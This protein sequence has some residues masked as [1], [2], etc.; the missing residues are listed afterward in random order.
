MPAH[1]PFHFFYPFIR[2]P[3]RTAK[4]PPSPRSWGLGAPNP[5]QRHR[6]AALR[7]PCSWGGG[8]SAWSQSAPS[9]KRRRRQAPARGLAAVNSRHRPI[10]NEKKHPSP[11]LVGLGCVNPGPTA[12]AGR[13]AAPRSWGLG[14]STQRQRHWPAALP[15]PCSLDGCSSAW[16]QSAPSPKTP[17]AAS[18]CSWAC[19]RQ[20]PSPP[21]SERKEASKPP[22]LGAWMRQPR[23]KGTGRRHCRPAGGKPLLV[24]LPP[25]TSAIAPT[26]TKRRAPAP[27]S[28]GGRSSAR[29]QRHWPPALP[30]YSDT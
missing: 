21:H 8:A 23:A 25:S 24:G 28:W 7:P 26:E 16:S 9:P 17:Q 1:L 4:T 18:P 12:L 20:L 6:L 15:P 14:A 5:S 3:A 30:A 19:R 11:L 22:T 13:T 27:C 10:R 29:R 2:I